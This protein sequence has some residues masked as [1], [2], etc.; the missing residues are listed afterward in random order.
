MLEDKYAPKKVDDVILPERIKNI[1]LKYSEEEL[2]NALF[3]GPPG[4]GKTTIAKILAETL[5]YETKI[6]NGSGKDRN[7]NL[8][9]SLESFV[10]NKS[11]FNDN[12]LKLVVIDEADGLNENSTQPALRYFIEEHKERVR[13]IF[14]AN[15]KNAILEAIQSRLAAIDFTFS[16]IEK[17][18]ILIRISQR[19]IGILKKENVIFEQKNL[20]KYILETYPD[21]RSLL[22]LIDSNIINGKLNDFNDTIE[23]DDLIKNLKDKNYDEVR[24]WVALNSSIKLHTINRIFYEKL[25]KHIRNENIPEFIVCMAEYDYKDKFVDDHEINLSAML[26]EL[27]LRMSWKND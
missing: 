10:I 20:G 25:I 12:S 24:K 5:G 1:I 13:F 22:K 3:F 14:T 2:N 8:M 9:D 11:L 19:I 23:I 7:I 21:I 18:D 27:I 17:K 15:N 4:T 6:L 26:M 16:P